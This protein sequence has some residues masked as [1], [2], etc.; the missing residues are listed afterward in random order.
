MQAI[1]VPAITIARNAG[2]DG[3]VIV[4]RLLLSNDWHIVYNAMTDNFEDIISSGV[5]DSCRVCRCALQ[6]AASI[7]GMVLTTQA[8]LVEKI[9]R[10]KP[11]VPFVPG[12]T[13]T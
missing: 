11:A 10:P 5:I 2:V 12:I 13:P 8:V 7:A 6:N 9:R 1:L 4:E 3:M